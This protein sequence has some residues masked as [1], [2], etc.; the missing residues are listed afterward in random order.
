M[1]S[2]HWFV[3]TRIAQTTGDHADA[4]IKTA[5]PNSDTNDGAGDETRTRDILLGRQKLYQLSYSR[6]K[7][8]Y[9]P[10]PPPGPTESRLGHRKTPTKNQRI[11]LVEEGGFEPP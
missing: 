1:G 5:A 7:P 2:R 10:D 4:R 8:A 9:K 3:S 6:A 11:R